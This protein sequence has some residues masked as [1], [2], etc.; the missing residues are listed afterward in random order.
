MMVV[1]S[2]FLGFFQFMVQD[3]NEWNNQ[4]VEKEWN[5]LV[6]VV[7]SVWFQYCVEGKVYCGCYYDGNLLIV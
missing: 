7:D 5:M 3:K 2:K 4:V 1:G 6:L